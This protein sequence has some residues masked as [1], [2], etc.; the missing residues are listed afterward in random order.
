MTHLR[1]NL[2]GEESTNRSEGFGDTCSN[3]FGEVPFLDF[4]AE[5]N[6]CGFLFLVVRRVSNFA[7]MI[8]A[9]HKFRGLHGA[10][11][12]RGMQEF[13]FPFRRKSAN[14]RTVAFTSCMNFRKVLGVCPSWQQFYTGP[15]GRRVWIPRPHIEPTRRRSVGT[16]LYGA[17]SSAL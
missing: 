8:Q 14:G 11:C 6:R 9:T 5:Q 7:S 3:W 4:V 10:T 17:C 16:A 12:H 15:L 2:C 13:L 1:Q